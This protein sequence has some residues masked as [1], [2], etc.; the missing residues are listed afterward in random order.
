MGR[1]SSIKMLPD[2]VRAQIDE[3]I[4]DG[5]LTL[6][7]L[8]EMAQSIGAKVSRSAVGRYRK[9]MEDRLAEY[10]Q[11]REIAGVWVSELGAEPDSPMGQLLAQMFQTLAFRTLA[12]MGE[13]EA[14]VDPKDLHFLARAMSDIARAEKTNLEVRERHREEW[15]TELRERA[16]AAESEVAEVAR[17]AGLTDEDAGRL[18]EILFGVVG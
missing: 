15:E 3:W 17:S 1:K 6:D 9:K 12:E 4:R 2:E 10:R 18:R 13:S 16:E 5:S 14:G 7:E 11:A 8:T